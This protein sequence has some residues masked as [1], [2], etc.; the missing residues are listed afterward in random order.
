[1]NSNLQERVGV[2]E[3]QIDHLEEKL[4][5]LKQDV[6][7]MQ[8]DLHAKLTEMQ[9]ASTKQHGELAAKIGEIQKFRDRWVNYA[10]A[11]GVIIA[12]ASANIDTILKHLK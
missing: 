1:M 12:W 5:D 10:V 8:V 7:N 6:R 3:V 9:E 2:T 11:G 4:D